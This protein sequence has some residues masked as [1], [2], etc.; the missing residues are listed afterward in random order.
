MRKIRLFL[1]FLLGFWHRYDGLVLRILVVLLVERV[2]KLWIFITLLMSL[3]VYCIS[4]AVRKS[5]FAKEIME[6]S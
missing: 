2:R 4:L 1:L 5:N 6:V 3:L